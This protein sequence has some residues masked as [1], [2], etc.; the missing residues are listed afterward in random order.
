MMLENSIESLPHTSSI[1][2]NR[3]KSL[4]INSY[5]DL[6]NY[7]PF[8][9]EDFSV[10]SKIK[11]VQPGETVTVSGKIVDVKFHVTRTHLKI[12]VFMVL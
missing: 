10:I 2:I 1:T 5:F 7:F 3:L 4:G 12:Q 9:Y 6:L 8:R 11:D